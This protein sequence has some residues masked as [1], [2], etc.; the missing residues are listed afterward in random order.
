MR[1]SIERLEYER[2]RNS[3]RHSFFLAVCVAPLIVLFMLKA[4]V[5]TFYL[6]LATWAVLIFIDVVLE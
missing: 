4:P 6:G 5:S 1:K 2:Q 3:R